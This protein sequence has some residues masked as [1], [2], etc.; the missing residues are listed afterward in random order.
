MLNFVLFW[1]LYNL[2]VVQ[3]DSFE[4]FFLRLLKDSFR[5]SFPIILLNIN[6]K[7]WCLGGLHW[8]PE[9]STRSF[10]SSLSLAKYLPVLN[11]HWDLSTLQVSY[12]LFVWPHEV[13]PYACGWMGLFG[14]FSACKFRILLHKLNPSLPYQVLNSISSSQQDQSVL[15]QIFFL[16]PELGI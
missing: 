16:A 14:L 12:F 2:H 15:L 4:A 9:N 8:R 6:P 1:L 3:L 5:K 7:A 13:S 11:G 10:Q